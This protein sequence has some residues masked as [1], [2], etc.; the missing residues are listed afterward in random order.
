MQIRGLE[1]HFPSEQIALVSHERLEREPND[2]MEE[3]LEFLGLRTDVEFDTSRRWNETSKNLANREVELA[4]DPGIIVSPAEPTFPI[5]R[6]RWLRRLATQPVAPSR[7][8]YRL[9]PEMRKL[10]AAELAD[11]VAALRQ[12]W[13]ETPDWPDFR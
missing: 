11:D 8:T 1:Q 3:V 13:P 4:P 7:P 12:R 6:R 9:T 5:R 2:V 10:I